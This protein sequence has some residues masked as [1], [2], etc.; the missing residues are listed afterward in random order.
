M[1]ILIGLV[2]ATVL[3]IG[4]ARGVLFSLVF[5]SLP[6]VLAAMICAAQAKQ[7]MWGW[8]WLCVGVLAVIW[9]PYYLRHRA[10]QRYYYRAPAGPPEWRVAMQGQFRPFITNLGVAVAI[11]VV[12][13]LILIPF[14]PR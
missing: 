11:C 7:D 13:A 8:F 4:W 3:V 1:H 10:A 14:F 12:V 5:M 9:T 6:V 2:I